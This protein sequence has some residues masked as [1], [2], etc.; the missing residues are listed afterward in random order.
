MSGMKNIANAVATDPSVA[1][2]LGMSKSEANQYATGGTAKALPGGKQGA[3]PTFRSET[4]REGRS[5]ESKNVGS[6]R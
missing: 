2:D 6:K 3:T 5:E 1:K 4:Q